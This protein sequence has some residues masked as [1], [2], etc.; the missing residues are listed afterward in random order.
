MPWLQICSDRPR[1]RRPCISEWRDETHHQTLGGMFWLGKNLAFL[2]TLTTTVLWHCEHEVV[3]DSWDLDSTSAHTR[4]AMSTTCLVSI[5]PFDEIEITVLIKKVLLWEL[6]EIRNVRWLSPYR[7]SRHE[8]SFHPDRE[9]VLVCL[10]IF[11]GFITTTLPWHNAW[12]EGT[13]NKGWSI[14]QIWTI[15]SGIGQ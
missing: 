4:W 10:W 6:N 3:L 1:E 8:R 13:W 15:K 2:E 12:Q 7:C 11:T 9:W 14:L 5:C